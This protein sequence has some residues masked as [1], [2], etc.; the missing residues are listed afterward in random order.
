M[1]KKTKGEKERNYVRLIFFDS[2]E[3][4]STYKA[5]SGSAG[6]AGSARGVGGGAS[7]VESETSSGSSQQ[8]GAT[9]YGSVARV[10]EGAEETRYLSQSWNVQ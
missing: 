6:A 8:G 3:Y 9:R 10:A 5:G 7:S 1:N 4:E 2:Y